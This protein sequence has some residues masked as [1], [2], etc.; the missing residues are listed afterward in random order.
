MATREIPRNEWIKFFDE[1]SKHHE[2]WIVTME[3]LGYDL[4]DQEET[5][6]LPLIG[7]SG[8]V[9]ARENRV[10]IMLGDK[11]DQH[12]TRIIE[13]PKRVWIELAEEPEHAAITV[14]SEDGRTTLVRFRHIPPEQTERQLPE[15]AFG[16]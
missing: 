1:F 3:I 2:R 10:E 16:T 11:P 8:D 14:E 13:N 5:A 6:A 7:I 4:G 9:K 15:R 12:L